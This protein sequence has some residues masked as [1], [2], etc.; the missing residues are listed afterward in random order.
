MPSTWL[1]FV[2]PIKGILRE[3]ED[4]KRIIIRK[5]ITNGFWLMVVR[6]MMV[7]KQY[8]INRNHTPDFEFRSFPRL[9]TCDTARSHDAGQWQPAAGPSQ[10]CDCSALRCQQLWDLVFVFVFLHPLISTKTHTCLSPTSGARTKDA[11]L[12]EMTLKI[13]ALVQTTVNVLSTFQLG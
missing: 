8:A 5:K 9:V 3:E 7:W 13:M 6:L 4:K 1:M 2:L 10:P 12:L 11:L